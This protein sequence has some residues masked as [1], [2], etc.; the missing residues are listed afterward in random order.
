VDFLGMTPFHILALSQIPN[1]PLFQALMKVYKVDIIRTRDKFGSSPLDYLCL[2]H[3]V[4]IGL[5]LALTGEGSSRQR[6][7]ELL[8]F[9]LATYERL[10]SAGV[11]FVESQY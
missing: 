4:W 5:L 10:E 6:E 1:I 11:G 3:R 7:I 8:C 2:S 9:K